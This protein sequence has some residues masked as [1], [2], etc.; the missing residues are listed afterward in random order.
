MEIAISN[1]S[2][3]ENYIGNE[4]IPLDSDSCDIETIVINGGDW[5]IKTNAQKLNQY[6]RMQATLSERLPPAID[7]WIEI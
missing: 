3:D 7:S 4:T 6:V 5:I 1:L 2:Q